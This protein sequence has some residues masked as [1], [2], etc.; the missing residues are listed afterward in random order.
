MTV[1]CWNS[2]HVS[3]FTG[4]QSLNIKEIYARAPLVKLFAQTPRLR[5]LRL[6]HV[7][8]DSS[9]NVQP[10]AIE[11]FSACP[12]LQRLDA[13][14]LHYASAR[15][16]TPRAWARTTAGLCVELERSAARVLPQQEFF[17]FANK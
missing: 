14:Q 3:A 11:L 17:S 9:E 5:L 1:G 16:F 15:D 13:R 10:W 6:D 12:S 8:F 2:V 7:F 4:L